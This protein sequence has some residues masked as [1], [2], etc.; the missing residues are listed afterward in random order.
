MD[1]FV[2]RAIAKELAETLKGG[3][4]YKI[5]QPYPTEL[6]LKIRLKGVSKNLIIS[7]NPEWPRVHI[8]KDIP[9]NPFSPPGFCMLL[10]KLILK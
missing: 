6:I 1:S 4:I 10:R 8:I 2:I 5:H 7:A 9:E 3:R